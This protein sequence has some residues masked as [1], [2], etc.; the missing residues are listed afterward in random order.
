M[1]RAEAMMAVSLVAHHEATAALERD[2]EEEYQRLFAVSNAAAA[3]AEADGGD[4]DA[5]WNR[6]MDWLAGR[7]PLTSGEVASCSSS[8]SVPR[9]WADIG[10]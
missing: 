7:C 1:T 3:D 4:P 8:P 10:L 5:V 2:D 6:M 9:T